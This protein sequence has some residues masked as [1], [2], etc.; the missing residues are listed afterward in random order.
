ASCTACIACCK[1]ILCRS[2]AGMI[3]NERQRICLQQAIQAVQEALEALQLGFAYDAVTVSL[4]GASDALL[5]LTGER[6]TDKVVD[7]VFARF[8]VGK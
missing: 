4:D 2:F 1:Q 5:Q 7:T 3:A 8:C 6:V